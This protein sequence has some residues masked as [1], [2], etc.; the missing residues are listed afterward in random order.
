MTTE[1]KSLQGVW[2]FE[3]PAVRLTP[4]PTTSVTATPTLTPTL[5]VTPTRTATPMATPTS[6]P[7][8]TAT[9]TRTATPSQTPTLTR[10]PANTASVT[11]TPTMT[12][13]RTPTHTRTPTWTPTLTRTPTLTNTPTASPTLTPTTTPTRTP[14][15]TLT[16]TLTPTPTPPAT[17]TPTITPTSTPTLTPTHTPTR[18]NTPTPTPTEVV[19]CCIGTFPLP[20]E[21]LGVSVPGTTTN[22]PIA[23]TVRLWVGQGIRVDQGAGWRYYMITAVT[24]D[25]S[26][27]VCGPPLS[28]GVQV[29]ALEILPKAPLIVEYYVQHTVWDAIAQN[30]LLPIEY[31]QEGFEGPEG[32]LVSFRATQHE[33]NGVSQGYL[34][35]RLNGALVGTQNGGNGIQLAGADV[36]V[37]SAA[38]GIDPTTCYIARNQAVELACTVVG[39]PGIGRF[40]S[41][42]LTYVTL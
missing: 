2:P 32:W 7:S 30:L 16:L 8:H 22:I 33:V 1:R 21:D 34:N 20:D 31:E 15:P 27:D 41:V 5:T 6:T 24:P 39:N 26:I 42:R 38:D 11:F 36:W 35:V 19:E 10:T 13:T 12:P 28:I 29:A 37:E 14:T 3:G 9:P 23:H 18:T 40:L 4:T 17:L 25:T